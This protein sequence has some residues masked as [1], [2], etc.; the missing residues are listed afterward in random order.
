MIFV[1]PSG[2]KGWW[3]KRAQGWGSRVP[4][5]SRERTLGPTAYLGTATRPARG[6]SCPMPLG[7]APTKCA[8]LG[9]VFVPEGHAIIAQRFNVGN[10]RP[11]HDKSRRDG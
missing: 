7:F 2:A 3:V 4:V 6:H 10:Q 1:G 5:C 11:Q 8:S 9:Q